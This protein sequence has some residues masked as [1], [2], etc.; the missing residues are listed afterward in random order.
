M[1]ATDTV[2]EWYHEG[3]VLNHSQRGTDGY[4]PRCNHD[5]PTVP[6]PK[7]GGGF[8]NEP[9]HPLTFEA[10]TAYAAVMDTY[11]E[12]ITNAG[13]VNNCRNIA[14]TNW[15][16][17]H[18]YLCALDNPPNSRKSDAFI[19]AIERIRTNSGAQVFRNLRGDRMHD[20]IDCSPAALGTGIDWSTVD[21]EG[22][23]SGDDMETIKAIQKQCNAGGFV[24]A[25]GQALTVDGVLGPNTQHAMNSLAAAAAQ[26]PVPGPQGPKGDKGATGA[27]GPKGAT[28]A[29]GAKGDPGPAGADGKPVELRIVADTVLP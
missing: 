9:V 20:Q 24:G 19:A 14:D 8:Y 2:R 18:A 1:A 23:G 28:G 5:H 22:G 12:S 13:G 26:N 17:L 11:G 4:R 21:G 27:T 7:D 29:K 3:V 25:N 10:W 6:I 16:S 15:P